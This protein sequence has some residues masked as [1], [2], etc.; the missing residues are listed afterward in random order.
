MMKTNIAITDDQSAQIN[1]LTLHCNTGVV[2]LPMTSDETTRG[3]ASLNGGEIADDYILRRQHHLNG[4][5]VSKRVA[6]NTASN[7]AATTAGNT[8]GLSATESH[9]VVGWLK[10]NA[11]IWLLAMLGL[12]QRQHAHAEKSNQSAPGHQVVWGQ[13]A[14]EASA[15]AA[16]VLAND[17]QLWQNRIYLATEDLYDIV[18]H[19]S[20]HPPATVDAAQ[21]LIEHPAEF[22]KADGAN[23]AGA[24]DGQVWK[25]DLIVYAK[26]VRATQAH[27][28]SHKGMPTDEEALA[29]FMQLA[30]EA[31]AA[32]AQLARQILQVQQQSSQPRSN[33]A[34]VEARQVLQDDTDLWK[35]KLT[36]SA[37]DLQKVLSNPTAHPPQTVVAALYMLQ[38]PESFNDASTLTPPGNVSSGGATSASSDYATRLKLGAA[39][40]RTDAPALIDS[41]IEAASKGGSGSEDIAAALLA[42]IPNLPLDTTGY[43]DDGPEATEAMQILLDD[44]SLW[45]NKNGNTAQD[46]QNVV[47]HP[48]KNAP[49]TVAAATFLLQHPNT[50]KM[51]DGL[52]SGGAI[53]GQIWKRDLVAAIDQANAATVPMAGNA[54]DMNT[55]LDTTGYADDGPEATQAMQTLLD[56]ASLWV[57]KNGI[58]AQDLQNVV[59]HPEKNAPD[60]I[61]AATFL[62]Q[63]PNTFKIADGLASGGAIDGQIWK[64][65]LVAAMD[66]AN[67][68]AALMAANA[69]DPNAIPGRV[70]AEL[71]AMGASGLLADDDSDADSVDSDSVDTDS[72]DSDSVN[73]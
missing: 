37:A 10:N 3:G 67:A 42:S 8:T 62:L 4:D 69:V 9:A 13:S 12:V 7:T 23:T 22:R 17:V 47:D 6:A 63:H 59:D 60:T 64:R 55:P 43:A 50:F 40:A 33:T 66:Q 73:T 51:A 34:A 32:R 58:T 21:T 48:E 1:A 36:L 27:A 57:G 18:A 26:N 35:G 16:E 30:L 71:E 20:Q 53:D 52:A 31:A 70:R 54:V 2:G 39:L 72:V 5:R 28:A 44:A 56:D 68:A 38:H 45:V 15:A 49:D 41:A 46:L 61:A 29:H 25:Q 65:D 24:V 14:E 11:P 19:P